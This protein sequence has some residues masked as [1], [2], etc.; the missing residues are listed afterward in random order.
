MKKYPDEKMSEKFLLMKFRQESK[1]WYKKPTK[2]PSPQRKKSNNQSS[3]INLPCLQNYKE[4]VLL[5]EH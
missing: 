5:L 2:H 4:A 3:P 1:A